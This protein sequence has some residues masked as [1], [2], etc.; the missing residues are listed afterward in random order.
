MIAIVPPI[1]WYV[2]FQYVVLACGT[3][4]PKLSGV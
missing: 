3:G 1:N 2:M 4:K